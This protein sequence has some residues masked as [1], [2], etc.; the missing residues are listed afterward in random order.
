[1][2]ALEKCLLNE[3]QRGFPL[4]ASPYEEIAGQLGVSESAVID[5]LASLQQRGFISRVGPVIA[6]NRAGASSLAAMAVPAGRLQEVA[7]I[8]SGYEEVNHNY[9]REHAFNLWFVV[10]A[11]DQARVAQVLDEISA[12]SGLQVLDLPLERSFYID[13]G[14]P[15]WC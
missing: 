6:P 3:Y 5:A 4:C 10:T 13:L 11:V 12:V 1:M 7:D 9:E 15:L 8:V 2:T 14:F